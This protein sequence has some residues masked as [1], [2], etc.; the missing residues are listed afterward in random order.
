MS[1]IAGGDRNNWRYDVG[2]FGT[3]SLLATDVDIDV[4]RAARA[5]MPPSSEP[6]GAGAWWLP[7]WTVSGAARAL[8]NIVLQT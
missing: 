8:E 7:I 6:W 5:T 2:L 4:L 3:G 1:A